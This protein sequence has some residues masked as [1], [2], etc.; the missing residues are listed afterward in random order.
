[1]P[2]AAIFVGAGKPVAVEEFEPLP[3]GSRDVVVELA[4]SGICHSDLSVVQGRYGSLFPNDTILG[5]EGTGSVLAIGSEVTRLKRGDRVVGSCIPACGACWYCLQ[6]LA[7]LCDL[8]GPPVMCARATASG[9][10]LSTMAGLGTFASVMTCSEAS[11]VRVETDIPD[12]QLALLGCSVATGVGAAVN[13][14]TIRPGETVAVIGCGGVG[15]SVVQGARVTGASRIIAIDPVAVKRATA[16]R[17]GATEVIDPGEGDVV[18]Q[19]HDL[20]GGRGVDHAFEAVGATAT[21]VE[22]CEIV[23]KGGT[24]IVVSSTPLGVPL[25]MSDFF[26]FRSQGKNLLSSVYGSTNGR[27][28]FQR[29][30]NLVH[31]GRLDLSSMVSDVVTLDQVNEALESM[32]TGDAVRTVIT[33]Y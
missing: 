18:R 22:A 12:A 24:V 27:R 28:D 26:S 17:L 16:S 3:P 19:V 14:A 33:S 20:T 10:E 7:H 8:T 11:V 4:A 5:H 2:R 9:R 21:V 32:Q 6:G 29:Y 31:S 15:Q 1:M 25:T 30:L 23:R 13:T